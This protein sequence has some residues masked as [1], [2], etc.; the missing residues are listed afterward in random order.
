L[1]Q[2]SGFVRAHQRYSALGQFCFEKSLQLALARGIAT[3]ARM[4]YFALIHANENVLF[5]LWHQVAPR[6][7]R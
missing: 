1:I 5:E 6:L 3:A 2:A 7:S 4:P